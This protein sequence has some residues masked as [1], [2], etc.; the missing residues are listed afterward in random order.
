DKNMPFRNIARKPRRSAANPRS[1]ALV[2]TKSG[3]MLEIADALGRTLAETIRLKAR[4]KSNQHIADKL[5]ISRS[6]VDQHLTAVGCL[7][8]HYA[9]T[10]QLPKRDTP[11]PKSMARARRIVETTFPNLGRKQKNEYVSAIARGIE[12]RIPHKAAEISALKRALALVPGE[13]PHEIGLTLKPK[14]S[15]TEQVEEIRPLLEIAAKRGDRTAKRL[16]THDAKSDSHIKALEDGTGLAGRHPDLFIETRYHPKVIQGIHPLSLIT[17][18]PLINTLARRGE[19]IG[20]AMQMHMNGKTQEQIARKL[21]IRQDISR[22]IAIGSHAIFGIPPT[23]NRMAR[24][25]QKLRQR[26]A[27]VLPLDAYSNLTRRSIVEN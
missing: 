7:L 10:E 26:N 12:N 22:L 2:A 19:R 24:E 14:Q 6:T 21:G 3:K 9:L 20:I 25:Y 23:T 27:D 18:A 17:R 5:G 13:F 1:A 4:K 11:E 15:M 16:L 8:R